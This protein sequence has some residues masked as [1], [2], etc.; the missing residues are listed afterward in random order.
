MK[1]TELFY[2]GPDP[3]SPSSPPSRSIRLG[4]QHAELNS[5]GNF[6]KE[7]AF[8]VKNNKRRGGAL[9]HV[10]SLHHLFVTKLVTIL[11]T[12]N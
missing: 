8:I 2:Y 7:K 5:F 12:I 11:L 4:K 10:S 3:E 6:M 1:K 9:L